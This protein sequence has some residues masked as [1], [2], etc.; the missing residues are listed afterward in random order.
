MVVC[1]SLVGVPI[2]VAV[3]DGLT[4]RHELEGAFLKEHHGLIRI[5]HEFREVELLVM[6]IPAEVR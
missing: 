1:D 3:A 5:R 2:T 4:R 6:R